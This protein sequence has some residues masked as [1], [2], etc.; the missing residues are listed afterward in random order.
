MNYIFSQ[1][2]NLISIVVKKEK[3]INKEQSIYLDILMNYNIHTKSVNHIEMGEDEVYYLV[4]I[5]N[6]LNLI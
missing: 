5:M 6:L 2:N 4:Q 3:I 1:E